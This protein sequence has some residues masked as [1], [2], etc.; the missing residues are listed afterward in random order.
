MVLRRLAVFSGWASLDAAEWVCAGDGVEQDEVF[1]L[2]NSLAEKSL[3][4]IEGNRAPRYR[5]IGTI[6]EYAAHRLAE[7][8]EAGLARQTHLA[9]FTELTE[10]AEPHLRRAEQLEWLATL[11]VE[12]DNIG[13]AMRGALAAGEASA[14]MRLAASA[15]S[16]W[17]LAGHRAEGI[18][19]IMA[20]TNVPGEVIDEIRAIVYA[21]CRGI[22]DFWERRRTPRRGVDPRGAPTRPGQSVPLPR[23]RGS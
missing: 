10:T 1:E 21:T 8:G 18:E 17:W 16:Y 20:A 6:Q 3:L 2:L 19:L 4:L 5:M 22:R 13:S 11:G 7:A 23:A 9:Y 12:H 15:G 14:A